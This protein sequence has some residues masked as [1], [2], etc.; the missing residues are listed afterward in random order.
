MNRITCFSGLVCT[1]ALASTIGAQTKIVDA[2]G[3][4]AGSVTTINAALADNTVTE[5]IVKN[6]GI[7]EEGL[8]V[9]RDVIIR[10]E[11]PNNR[12][13]IAMK[14]LAS[15]PLFGP[16]DGIYLGGDGLSGGD[17]AIT[18]SNFILVPHTDGSVIDDAISIS[19]RSGFQLNLTMENILIAPNN[20]S[21]A[22]LASTVWD[23]P[24]LSA[25]GVVRI[26]D[27]GIYLMADPAFGGY[28]GI[29]NADLTNVVI[30]GPGGAN[31][32]G[33]A[34]VCY[35]GDGIINATGIG[36]SYSVRTGAQIANNT[37]WNV[38]GTR[39]NPGWITRKNSLNGITFF[40]GKISM[41]HVI[42]V[43]NTVGGIRADTDGVQ[44]IDITNSLF[45]NNLD[46]GFYVSAA[47]F[48]PMT[49]SVKNTTFFA[50]GNASADAANVTIGSAVTSGLVLDV[51]DCVMG[52]PTRG[53]LNLSA[54][55]GVLNVANCGLPTTGA[56]ALAEVI[57]A[58][59]VGPVNITSS[60]NDD[61]DFVNPVSNPVA[62][63]SFNILGGAYAT[64]SSTN[65]ALNGWGDG[66]PAAEIT[67]WAVY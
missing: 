3:A 44:S 13:V 1:L 6:T 8:L 64:A 14:G 32:T 52:G 18:L 29:V 5:I 26:P 4:T 17:M 58:N 10:G 37:T 53:L 42:A 22:P 50:N 38:T 31:V 28:Q 45:A 57:G 56:D 47:T 20:G 39:T 27:D 43:E 60:I 33:E 9:T 63:D 21:N 23:D 61:P 54:T 51:T 40:D 25:P 34:I 11:D 16:G 12:P 35:A 30:I 24:D 41:D 48:Q 55:G 15:Q 36:I 49:Y 46:D 62:P 7:Y 19:P 2:T 59:S 67:D 65:G 66:P